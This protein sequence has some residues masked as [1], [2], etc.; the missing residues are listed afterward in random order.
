MPITFK[1]EPGANNPLSIIQDRVRK[2]FLLPADAVITCG[3]TETTI[4]LNGFRAVL[5]VGIA[6]LKNGKA[7]DPSVNQVIALFG[8]VMGKSMT[9]AHIHVDNEKPMDGAIM[10]PYDE[11]ADEEWCQA[12]SKKLFPGVIHLYQ[13]T[14]MHQPVLGTGSGSIYK[15][16]FIGPQ[17]KV[18]ARLK[19]NHVSMRV[20]TDENVAPKGKVLEVFERLGV[21]NAYEDRLTSHTTM[22]GAYDHSTAGEYRAL[23]GAFYAALRPWITSGFPAIAKLAEGVK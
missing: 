18:A 11:M 22:T 21:V 19:N 13:A 1:T 2:E 10:P 20:T 3:M 14:A 8:G 23:F 6:A 9:T 16:C 7:L 17:L 5:P 12:M 15:T 4:S